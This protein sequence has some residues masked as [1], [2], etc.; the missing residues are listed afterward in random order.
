MNII[1]YEQ[2]YVSVYTEFAVVVRGILS[3]AID[4]ARDGVPIP[5][6]IQCRAKDPSHLRPKLEARGLIESNEIEHEIKDL[7]GA[8]LIFYTNTDVDRFLNSGL[9]WENFAVE[10]DQTR[11]HHPLPE[12]DRQRYQ[13][14]H[15]TVR[16]N[17][18]RTKL[19]EYARFAGMRCEIQI[20]TILNHAWA[21]TSHDILYKGNTTKG[22]G[23][24]AGEAIEKRL[25][26]V[27]DEYLLPAGYELHKVQHDYERLMQ[28]KELF[29]R[30]AIEALTKATDNNEREELL[31][32][33]KEYL[34]PN[35]DDIRAVYPD[36]RTALVS[37]YGEA[38]KTEPKPIETPFGDL[39]GKS[40]EDVAKL[41]IEIFRL[42]RYVD[43]DGTFASLST[44]YKDEDSASLRA[45]IV[46]ATEELAQHNLNIWKEAGPAVQMQLS[47]VIAHL[48]GEE[49]LANRSILIAAW[50]EFLKTELRGSTWTADTVT[51]ST[52]ALPW[53]EELAKIRSQAIDGLFDLFDRSG[54][55]DEQ[56]EVIQALWGATHLP[57]QAQ[58][59]NELC[60]Q[61]INDTTRVVDFVTNRIDTQ[62][63]PL[64][65]HLEHRC[66][67]I[68]TRWKPVVEEDGDRFGCRPANEALLRAILATAM[69]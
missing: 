45:A 57:T 40:A 55:E 38:K 35:Y 7:A 63:L 1:E 10:E 50:H 56:W 48:S 32:N 15:Y 14:I 12:N 24:A 65:K 3:K 62:S 23:S 58:F 5:Q 43:I 61:A 47:T 44:L 11:V 28:G 46:E 9:V 2:R 67:L 53:S 64:R 42:L 4:A 69:G 16:L 27:M 52:G 26:R 60:A 25:L 41:I 59:S 30:G 22:F 36:L 39:P 13:A 17:D 20:Q 8:R 29:D 33:F 49:R 54:S 34:L 51:L 21:E 31:S 68:Y 19:P 6:S 18:D 37:A 66:L